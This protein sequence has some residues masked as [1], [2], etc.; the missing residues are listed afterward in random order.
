MDHKC[1]IFGVENIEPSIIYIFPLYLKQKLRENPIR[2]LIEFSILY[3][4]SHISFKIFILSELLCQLNFLN[5]A[6]K[7]ENQRDYNA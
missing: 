7:H 5:F 4:M 6:A 1:R 2:F 3:H